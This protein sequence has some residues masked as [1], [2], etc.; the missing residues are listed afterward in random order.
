MVLRSDEDEGSLGIEAVH[1]FDADQSLSAQTRF[2]VRV[3]D[4]V[5]ARPVKTR[6]EQKGQHTKRHYHLRRGRRDSYA[7]H[8]SVFAGDGEAD[9]ERGRRSRGS[10]RRDC[11][12][13]RTKSGDGSAGPISRGVRALA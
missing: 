8:V 11:S 13:P 1:A 2:F 3:V 7:F 6:G 9:R 5:R 4:A 12:S 10:G